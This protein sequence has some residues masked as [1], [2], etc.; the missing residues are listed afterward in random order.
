ME[1][2]TNQTK[3]ACIIAVIVTVGVAV[4]LWRMHPPAA[5]HYDT[6]PV[7]RDQILAG[8]NLVRCEFLLE[9]TG[10]ETVSI[11]QDQIGQQF[12][13]YREFSV[14]VDQIFGVPETFILSTVVQAESQFRSRGS[15]SGFRD[16]GI[17]IG[18]RNMGIRI[19]RNLAICGNFI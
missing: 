17:R 8:V 16:A 1:K 3:W 9:A 12:C 19:R 2:Q 4:E 14:V 11:V 6:V 18:R 7:E 13:P 15:E 5:I 10:E